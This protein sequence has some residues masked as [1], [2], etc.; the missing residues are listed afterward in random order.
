MND[1]TGLFP[2]RQFAHVKVV[3]RG[4]SRFLQTGAVIRTDINLRKVWVAFPDGK[5]IRLS[6]RS[7]EVLVSKR[8]KG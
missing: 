3:R 1:A 2:L 8:S 5:V 7:V 6:N 4:H